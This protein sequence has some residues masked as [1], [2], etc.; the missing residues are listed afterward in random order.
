M[1]KRIN[2][3]LLFLI[4][5]LLIGMMF[6]V[7]VTYAY[8]NAE[9][10]GNESESTVAV[11]GG[12]L[13]INYQNNSG[14]IN[15]G[16]IMPGWSATKNFTITATIDYNEEYDT[17]FKIWY[18]MLLVIDR[19]DFLTG[20]LEYMLSPINSD[21]N[22]EGIF[23]DDTYK[24][25]PT[26]TNTEGISMG[27]GYLPNDTTSHT[28]NLSLR[29]LD[30]D[31]VDQTPE[32]EGKFYARVNVRGSDQAIVTV[33][34]N[35]GNLSNFSLDTSNKSKIAKDSEIYIPS[36]IKVGY[37]FSGW[38]IVNGTGTTTGNN[39]VATS[40]NITIKAIYREQSFANDTWEEIATA[41]RNGNTDGYKVGETREIMLNG[42]TN[43]ADKPTFT[44]RIAN[45]QTP[46]SCKQEGFSQTACGFVLEFVDI[47]EQR[48]LNS[49]LTNVGGWPATVMRTYLNEEFFAKLPSDLQSVIAAT[50]V[51]SGHGSNDSSN[52]TSTDKLYLLSAREV[53]VDGSQ[54]AL[55]SY[56]TAYNSTRQLDYY[57]NN[58]V[59]TSN[60]SGA[61]KNYAGTAAV[62]WLR[63]A[64]SNYYGDFLYVD[65]SGHWSGTNAYNTSVGVAPAFRIG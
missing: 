6:V 58:K 47:V 34:L 40:S 22:K 31:D 9:V 60:Y 65:S 2:K 7:Y 49:D 19:N 21:V 63:T 20:S 55:S 59:T 57:A 37:G 45:K 11:T 16:K 4:A 61:I 35:G 64:G 51:V 24:P 18:D 42:L 52:F 62:W 5:F 54:D 28:Y 1:K 32:M 23:I 26:G 44:L 10:S 50:T 36:P 46:E 25:I 30:R 12:S 56:D 27:S 33:D 53:C 17:N 48:A 29:Y 3:K 41:I 43:T 39:L 14:D 13:T 38:K 15:A 8:Y